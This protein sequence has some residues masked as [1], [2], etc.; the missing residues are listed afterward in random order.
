[1]IKRLALYSALI[2]VLLAAPTF[3]ARNPMAYWYDWKEVAE[4]NPAIAVIELGWENNTSWRIDIVLDS[5]AIR[6]QRLLL[7]N[8]GITRVMCEKAAFPM[9]L[10]VTY[11][12][13]RNWRGLCEARGS[14]FEADEAAPNN[15]KII[16][17]EFSE[18]T[19]TYIIWLPY[20]TD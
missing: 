3:A 17:P 2:S 6:E 20:K 14:E 12:G 19:G 9:V 4:K 5:I 11:G 10:A 18:Y 13:E 16:V 15:D 1:M 7:F 8:T